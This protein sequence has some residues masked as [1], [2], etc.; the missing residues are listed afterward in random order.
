MPLYFFHLRNGHDLLTDPDGRSLV[1]ADV[2]GAALTEARGLISADALTGAI[3]LNQRIEV[4]DDKGR[5][6]HRLNFWDAVAV[7]RPR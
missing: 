7:T 1:L 2:A 5:V 4:E 3:H 6:I